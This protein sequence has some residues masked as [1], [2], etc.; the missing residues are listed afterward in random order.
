MRA[1]AAGRTYHCH[2][3]VLVNQRL[4]SSVHPLLGVHLDAATIYRNI[5]SSIIAIAL[6]GSSNAI[7]LE[8]VKVDDGSPS[9]LKLTASKF[10]NVLSIKATLLTSLKEE[11]PLVCD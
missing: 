11:S 6:G 10:L 5:Q 1:R 7:F 9:F 8:A 4:G 2:H 3:T